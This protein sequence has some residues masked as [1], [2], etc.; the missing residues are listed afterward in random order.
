MTAEQTQ[1][2][3]NCVPSEEKHPGRD[4]ISQGRLNSLA[5]IHCI[6]AQI[7]ATVGFSTVLLLSCAHQPAKAESPHTSGSATSAQSESDS[8][9]ATGPMTSARAE[10]LVAHEG[11]TEADRLKDE[12]RKP[13]RLLPFLELQPGQRVADLGAGDGYTTELIARGIGPEGVLFAQNNSY[14]LT[15]FVGKSWPTRLKRTVMK[16]V[17]RVDAEFESPLPAEAHSLDLITLLFSYHDV[18]AGGYDVASMNAAI[19]SSLRP[20]GLYVI[21]DHRA[22]MDA[23]ESVEKEK[24]RI[25]ESKVISQVETA[26]F[27]LVEEAHFLDDPSD[28]L[29]AISYKID[30]K[31]DRFLLK[32]RKPQ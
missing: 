19:F 18:I 10:V 28:D 16:Q 21:A 13:T 5:N 25:K 2:I 14:S 7:L 15:N 26:G 3:R 12:R 23:S 17:V 24:H 6:S 4:K 8:P 9:Y 31:T 27:I 11:R 29:T 30:F 32:F 20:G 22:A 1:R